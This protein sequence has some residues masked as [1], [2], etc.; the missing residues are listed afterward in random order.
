MNNPEIHEENRKSSFSWM[1]LLKIAIIILILIL[2]GL[3]IKDCFLTKT[4]KVGIEPASPLA[5]LD[6][7]TIAK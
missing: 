7:P 6:T 5:P 4:I 3:L 2:V 1:G